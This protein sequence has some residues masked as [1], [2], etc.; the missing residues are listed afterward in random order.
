M[1]ATK[2]LQKPR[3]PTG[4]AVE[5]MFG[6]GKEMNMS[7]LSR[8]SGVAY[9]TCAGY[10]NRSL[11]FAACKLETFARLCQG[12]E[13]SDKEILELVKTFYERRGKQ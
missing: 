13:L 12:R 11:D 8:R 10:R 6:S 5:L 7:E 3:D 1:P 4:E 9:P 2:W